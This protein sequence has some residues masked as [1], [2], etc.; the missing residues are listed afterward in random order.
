MCLSISRTA[1]L[2]D[3]LCERLEWE[4]G[5]WNGDGETQG[6]ALGDLPATQDRD[7]RLVQI[8]LHDIGG[9]LGF[10]HQLLEL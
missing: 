1:S 6:L 5:L 9:K 10:L 7:D 8:N 3:T 2:A 4:A